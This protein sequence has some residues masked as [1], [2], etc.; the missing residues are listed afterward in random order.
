MNEKVKL[1]YIGDLPLLMPTRNVARQFQVEMWLDNS[2][3]YKEMG[4]KTPEQ[5]AIEKTKGY[6]V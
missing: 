4:L 6:V 5:V 1:F 3:I 2:A